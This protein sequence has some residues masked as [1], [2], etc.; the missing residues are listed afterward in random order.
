MLFK[1]VIVCSDNSMKLCVQGTEL[2]IVKAGGTYSCHWDLKGWV[3]LTQYS[4]TFGFRLMEEMMFVTA[5]CR[6][7]VGPLR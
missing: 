5:V 7:A 2:V 3:L 4:T 6:P 1:E